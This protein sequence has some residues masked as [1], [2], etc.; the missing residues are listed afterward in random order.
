[1]TAQRLARVARA[2]IDGEWVADALVRLTDTGFRLVPEQAALASRAVPRHELALLPPIT[3]AHVH[4]GLADLRAGAPSP[5]ARVL[6]LGWRPDALPGLIDEAVA[7]HPALAVRFAGAFLTA[8]GG[9]PSDRAWAPPGSVVGIAD[10]AAARRAV[11]DQADAGASV[12]KVVCSAD[13]GP[14]LDD[15]CLAAVIAE[16]HERGLPVV[17]HAQGAEQ[18]ERAI[19]A[20]V[21]VFAHTPWA[22]RLADEDVRAA[23]ARMVWISTLAMHGRDRDELAFARATDNLARFAAAGGAVVYGTDLGNG[24]SRLELDEPELAALRQAGIEGT[25][26]VEALL[27]TALLPGGP[28]A[29][30]F[31]PETDDDDAV[32]ANLHRSR[33]VR[34]TDLEHA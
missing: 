27:A 18:A 19:A 17:A 23:A 8:A 22:Q 31:P 15:A 24:T 12:V 16:A 32:I 9:Y 28:T 2:R 7:A 26:L 34:L 29:S 5:V 30:A 14:V 13:D 21:D 6:D 20:G 4:L 1:M 33:P 25:A 11:R 10:V 3:D